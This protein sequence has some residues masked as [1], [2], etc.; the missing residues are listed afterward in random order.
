M[1]SAGAC[2]MRGPFYGPTFQVGFP[3]R[4]VEPTHVPRI[5]LE[6]PQASGCQKKANT[7]NQWSVR[8]AAYYQALLILQQFDGIRLTP[9]ASTPQVQHH[10]QDIMPP[11]YPTPVKARLLGASAY[12]EKHH[13]SHFKADLF[14]EFGIHSNTQ[15]WGILHKSHDRRHLEVETRGRKPLISAEDLHKM[16]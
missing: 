13:I 6:V 4:K 7:Q 12:L 8:V 14:R 15:G 9:L 16:E 2:P 11:H 1:A 5:V 3:T 10:D